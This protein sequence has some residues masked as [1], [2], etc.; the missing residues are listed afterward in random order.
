MLT[1]E[2]RRCKGNVAQKKG[3]KV[4]NWKRKTIRIDNDIY[5]RFKRACDLEGKKIYSVM[6]EIFEDYSERVEREME[7]EKK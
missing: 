5:L 3:A 4:I 7:K 2:M 1:K 6:H